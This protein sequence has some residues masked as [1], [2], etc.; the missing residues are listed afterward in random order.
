MLCFKQIFLAVLCSKARN[1]LHYV[2]LKEIK[3]I[4]VDVLHRLNGA[5]FVV[6]AT[7]LLFKCVFHTSEW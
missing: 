6:C 4:S 2:T 3:V 5:F 1:V 7:N